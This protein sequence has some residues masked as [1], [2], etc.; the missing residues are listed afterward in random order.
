MSIPDFIIL[1]DRFKTKG[2]D[3][4]NG[5]WFFSEYNCTKDDMGAVGL[6]EIPL[7][8]LFEPIKFVARADLEYFD[9]M[10]EMIINVGI[11]YP[12]VPIFII[13]RKSGYSD[14]DCA[15][16]AICNGWTFY[17]EEIREYFR[18]LDF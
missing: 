2:K 6:A 3:P 18:R 16:Q 4:R 15:G 7:G 12:Q 17:E 10:E 5:K 9:T 11:R 8:K 14:L 13:N 1:S